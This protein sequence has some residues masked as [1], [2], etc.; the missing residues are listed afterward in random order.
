MVGLIAGLL[1]AV[2]YTADAEKADKVTA[3]KRY[4]ES[5]AA[6]KK[7]FVP[8]FERTFSKRTLKAPSEALVDE[9]CSE[10]FK[11][12]SEYLCD[13]QSN[14]TDDRLGMRMALAFFLPAKVSERMNKA[15]EVVVSKHIKAGTV[16]K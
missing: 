15:V 10:S 7:G 13:G 1:M 14:M 11:V 5:Y 9:C 12:L 3:D 2:G 4:P 8:A 16:H 6:F